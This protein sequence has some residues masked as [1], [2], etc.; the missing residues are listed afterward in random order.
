MLGEEMVI[1]R[2][3]IE[4][5]K[6]MMR[7]IGREGDRGLDILAALQDLG[8]REKA[9]GVPRLPRFCIRNIKRTFSHASMVTTIDNNPLLLNHNRYL[10]CWY[11]RY[12]KLCHLCHRSQRLAYSAVWV[13]LVRHK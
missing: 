5:E 11:T 12:Y 7:V 10:H 8:L 3:G 6:R 1:G 2:S 13:L 9:S 4:S